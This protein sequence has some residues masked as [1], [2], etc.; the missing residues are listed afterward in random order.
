MSG[1]IAA[2]FWGPNINEH[3]QVVDLDDV[4]IKGLYAAGKLQAASGMRK[5]FRL[6]ITAA[7]R[8]EESPQD[9]QSQANKENEM[10][11]S[12]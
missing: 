1:G 2:N 5:T 8:W 3:A 10:K 11:I 6:Q 4:P 9:M 12:C 7:W